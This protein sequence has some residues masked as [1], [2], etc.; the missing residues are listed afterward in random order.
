MIVP[1]VCRGANGLTMAD[2]GSFACGSVLSIRN[3]HAIRRHEKILGSPSHIV[4]RILLFFLTMIP[5]YLPDSYRD[6]YRTEKSLSPMQQGI[7]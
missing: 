7:S 5:G 6:S 1:H 4:L 3:V 2:P